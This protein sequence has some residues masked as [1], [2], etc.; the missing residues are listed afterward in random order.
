MPRRPEI[1][2]VQLYPDRRL[3]KSDRN[4]YVLKF[5][6]PLQHRR[7]RRNCGTRDRREARRIQRECQERLLNGEYAASDGAITA[8]HVVESMTLPLR[9]AGTETAAEEPQGPTWQECYEKYLEHRRLR[10]R[11]VSLTEIVSRLGIA[12]RILERRQLERDGR[13]GLLMSDVATLDTLEDL[14]ARLLAGEECRYQQRS[15]HTVNSIL[16]VVMA[17]LRFCRRRG[18]IVDVPDLHRLDYSSVMKGRPITE[19]EFQRMLEATPHVVGESSGESWIFA[20][21]VLWESGFRVSDLMNFSWDNPRFIHPQWANRQSDVSVLSIPSFQK[22][23]KLQVVPMLPQLEEL[24]L[25]V[26][27]TQRHGWVVDPQPM[28]CL[29]NGD[30]DS[31]RPD[32]KDLAKLLKKY[33]FSEVARVCS[34]T[35]TSVRKWASQLKLGEESLSKYSQSRIPDGLRIQLLNRAQRKPSPQI[36]RISGRLTS[37]RV[38]RVIAKI[39]QVANVVVQHEDRRLGQRVKYA[40]AHDLRRGF[41]MRLINTGVSAETL[42]IVMR[43]DDFATTER[44]YGAIRSAQQAGLELRRCLSQNAETAH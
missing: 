23:G 15:P 28:E 22:N 13:E 18:M 33:S 4:G 34:V 20:L 24:L 36:K 5:Y 16:R 26:A 17:M 3:R 43:H 7:I 37:E 39:G 31:F 44:H 41:A 29:F 21:R 35:E 2:N 9:I 38:G 30:W 19:E 27:K 1:G 32:D 6:C 42:K 25:S 40:S 14:Q 12:E 10:V 11:E 8:A